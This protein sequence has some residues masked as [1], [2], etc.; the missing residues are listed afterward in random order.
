MLV[1]VKAKIH[2]NFHWWCFSVSST[3]MVRTL[4][5]HDFDSEVLHICIVPTGQRM[6][7]LENNDRRREMLRFT[8][9]LPSETFFLSVE[10]MKKSISSSAIHGD[11]SGLAYR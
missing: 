1:M 5:S 3:S 11:K 9:L 4:F 7:S 8:T 2:T 6:R 10:M